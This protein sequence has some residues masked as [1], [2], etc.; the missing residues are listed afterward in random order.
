[1]FGGHW[2]IGSHR[3]HVYIT[4]IRD[5]HVALW[6]HHAWPRVFP[7]DGKTERKGGQ[8]GTSSTE[9][10]SQEMPEHTKE[11]HSKVLS[12]CVPGAGYGVIY[13]GCGL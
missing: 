5:L 7:V 8:E 13:D 2:L 11:R 4:A 6:T 1:M 10:V 9:V 3:F 12:L